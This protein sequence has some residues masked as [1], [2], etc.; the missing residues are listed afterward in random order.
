MASRNATRNMLA[1]RGQP[2][3]GKEEEV[4]GQS[5]GA[6]HSR[7]APLIGVVLLGLLFVASSSAEVAPQIT[8]GR[9]PSPGK[10]DS[11]SVLRTTSQPAFRVSALATPASV[12]RLARR[13]RTG[14]FKPGF[15]RQR[16]GEAAFELAFVGQGTC[17][18][19]VSGE[20]A[21]YHTA[22]AQVSIT[23]VGGSS[24][25]LTGH[26]NAGSCRAIEGREAGSPRV[27]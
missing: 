10:M 26:P 1:R 24:A 20:G 7:R 5:W 6:R 12:C 17:T 2:A 9:M 15:M 23:V 8:F 13:Y 3:A 16:R 4:Q 11:I 27:E 19:D 14:E 18:I 21:D 22:K 25:H